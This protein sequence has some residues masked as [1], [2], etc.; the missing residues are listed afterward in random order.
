MSERKCRP[1]LESYSSTSIRAD[2]PQINQCNQTWSNINFD[3][4]VTSLTLMPA[5]RLQRRRQRHALSGRRR[6]SRV[7]RQLSRLHSPLR[8]RR[9]PSRPR[10]R[11]RGY[12]ARGYAYYARS[13]AQSDVDALDLRWDEAGKSLAPLDNSWRWWTPQL[14]DC[15]GITPPPSDSNANRRAI[16]AENVM[17][18]SETPASS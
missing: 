2:T 3:K 9:A 10:V 8:K 13:R 16:K 12:G 1:A 5:I 14:N 6:P 18:F 7:P 11:A 15:Q 4:H 17:T